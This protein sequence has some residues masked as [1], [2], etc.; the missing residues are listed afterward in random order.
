LRSK[1]DNIKRVEVLC[2][3]YTSFILDLMF[4]YCRL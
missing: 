2:V 1:I 3:L 4:F